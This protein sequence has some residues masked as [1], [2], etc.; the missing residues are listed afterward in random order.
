MAVFLAQISMLGDEGQQQ[1]RNNSV[2]MIDDV[3]RTCLIAQIIHKKAYTTDKALHILFPISPFTVIRRY[4]GSYTALTVYNSYLILA[5]YLTAP[6]AFGGMF[7]V[8]RL[9]HRNV[10][11]P[12]STSD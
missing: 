5:M 7:G 1:S 11:Y 8:G 10:V 4:V 9:F 12:R 2:T 3:V 6:W